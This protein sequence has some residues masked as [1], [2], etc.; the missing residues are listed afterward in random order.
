M[1]ASSTSF[2]WTVGNGTKISLWHDSWLQNSTIANQFQDFYFPPSVPLSSIIGK[3]T[4][5]IHINLPAEVFFF[6][7]S[8]LCHRTIP[9][10]LMPCSDR[11]NQLELSPCREHFDEIL[12]ES[13]SF[14][15]KK[16][17]GL[18]CL[19]HLGA[20]SDKLFRLE[21]LSQ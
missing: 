12:L 16:N 1:W 6:L 11:Q 20:T 10:W 17:F 14:H 19:E 13:G 2:M 9:S 5:L 18:R 15:P 7:N 21:I 4:W 8:S 3:D